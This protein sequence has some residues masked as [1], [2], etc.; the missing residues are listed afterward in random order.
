M[1]GSARAISVG[2]PSIRSSTLSQHPN[3]TDRQFRTHDTLQP[4]EVGLLAQV[5]FNS[6][7]CSQGNFIRDSR[8]RSATPAPRQRS[9][10]PHP[11]LQVDGG[12]SFSHFPASSFSFRAPNR[13]SSVDGAGRSDHGSQTSSTGYPP[14]GREHA[15]STQHSTQ[16]S[17]PVKPSTR[18]SNSLKAKFLTPHSE[19][20]CR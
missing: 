14:A 12:T 19:I 5:T 6:T 15:L 3:R 8:A 4:R 18:H 10:T 2:P 13:M 16:A 9:S 11:L 7:H 1:Q 20:D 17:A